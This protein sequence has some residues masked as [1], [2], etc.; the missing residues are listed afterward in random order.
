LIGDGLPPLVDPDAY[1]RLVADRREGL[2]VRLETEQH[3][4]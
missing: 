1:K 4:P 3:T 2:R